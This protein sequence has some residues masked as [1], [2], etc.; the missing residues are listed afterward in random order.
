MKSMTSK[1]IGFVFCR[2]FLCAAAIV[3]IALVL[4][5]GAILD[6]GMIKWVLLLIFA[7]AVCMFVS[8]TVIHQVRKITEQS[9]K[10]FSDDAVSACA[11]TS[12]NLRL[13]AALLDKNALL[14]DEFVYT[15]NQ[16]DVE[17]NDVSE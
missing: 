7:F 2:L 9:V 17:S 4:E 16:R 15:L 1:L 11:Q 13:I 6:D 10:K 14:M 5:R 8:L 3:I 12:E